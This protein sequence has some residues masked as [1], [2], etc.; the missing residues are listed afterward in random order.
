M[1]NVPGICLALIL[2][3][4]GFALTGDLGRLAARGMAVL[5]S[6]DVPDGEA[7]SPVSHPPAPQARDAT[8]PGARLPHQGPASVDMTTLAPGNR[9]VAWCGHAGDPASCRR[10]ALDVVD[11]QGHEALVSDLPS[12]P[13]AG[14]PPVAPS[15]PRRVV[16]RGSAP[17]GAITRGGMVIIEARG[18]AG[19]ADRE[20]IGPIV[21]LDVTR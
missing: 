4:G 8:A 10:V 16:V 14:R 11:P 5:Q 21:A 2:V 7:A 6:T 3:G 13:A 18:I 15:P 1:T 12:P 9:I 19:T 17:S 20:A